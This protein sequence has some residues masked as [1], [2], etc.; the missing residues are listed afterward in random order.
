MVPV[1]IR[2]IA[3]LM[4]L[5]MLVQPSLAQIGTTFCICS[6]SS[7]N[8]TFDFTKNCDDTN[9]Q[10]SEA[11][12]DS[13]CIIEPLPNNPAVTDLVPVSVRGVLISELDQNLQ[14]MGQ[15]V[16]FDGL[17]ENGDSLAFSSISSDAAQVSEAA[18]PRALQITAQGR[19][20][21]GEALVFVMVIFYNT[22]CVTLQTLSE[23]STIGWI[24]FVSS[25]FSQ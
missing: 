6:P 5:A 21:A 18:F 4:V 14:I 7:Y 16:P 10:P 22:D 13:A 23:G 9:L 11:V 17:F 19:N 12:V 1:M 24:T 20:A 3:I 25:V 2:T 15:I 8:I